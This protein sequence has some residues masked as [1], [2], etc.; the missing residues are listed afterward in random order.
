MKKLF[1]YMFL[2]LTKPVFGQCEYVWAQWTNQGLTDTAYA[3]LSVNGAPLG[4]T[5][6]ANYDFDFTPS[7]FSYTTFSGYAHLPTNNTVPRTTWAAGTG[8][9]TTMCFSQPVL[10]PVLL[11]S[12]IGNPNTPVTL[13][14]SNPYNLLFDGGG[15]TYANSTTINAVEGFCIIEFPGSFT[16]V[17][18]YSSTPEFYANLTWGVKNPLTAGLSFTNQCLNSPVSFSSALSSINLP[19]YF[20]S[21][22]WNFGDGSTSLLQNPAHN[23]AATGTYPVQLIVTSNSQCKDTAF[24]IVTVLAAY[25]SNNPVNICGGQSYTINSHTYSTTGLYYDTL[26]SVFGCDSI[27]TTQLA[28]GQGLNTINQLSI[29]SGSSYTFNSHL[30]TASGSYYD[31]LASISGCDSVVNTQ[32]TVNTILSSN[33]PQSIC[34]GGNYFFNNHAYSAT[35]NYYDTLTAVSGCDSVV[36]TQLSVIPFYQF[37]N[38]VSICPGGSY[39]F[40]SHVY[41]LP[42]DYNDTL[43]T[44]SGCDSI[45]ITSL[46][47]NTLPVITFNHP[48]DVCINTPAFTLNYTTPTGGVYS[49]AGVS[50]NLFDPQLANAGIHQ[51]TYAFTDPATNCSNTVQENITVHPSPLAQISVSPNYASFPDPKISFTDLTQGSIS[52][53]W[54]FGDNSVSNDTSGFH[55]YNEIGSFHISLTATDNFGCS[56]IAYE[57]VYIDGE[58]EF[59]VPNTFTPNGDGIND[60]F[61]GTGVGIEDFIMSIFDRWGKKVFES[62]DITHSWDAKNVQCDTY[63]YKINLSDVFGADHEFEGKVSVVR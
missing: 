58:F 46:T 26:T 29:C 23:Y 10:N 18:I 21:Y 59:Y 12:S 27:I 52:S 48:A 9:Q 62:N 51:L 43:N 14:F 38:P 32:L 40:N 57:T 39:N 13:A 60:S 37:N 55:V 7:I 11:L 49:G 6:T 61:A 3:T 56:D 20:I 50:N 19:G 53:E 5:M 44:I 34:C 4:M 22:E 35:G 45:I 17:T 33:N 1:L 42:G 16:C 15:N 2:L 31:T 24:G 41:N 30:Y 8:G 28:V 47:V 63:V 54:N 36:I 25:T